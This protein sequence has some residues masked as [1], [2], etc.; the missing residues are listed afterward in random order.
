[1]PKITHLTYCFDTN[2]CILRTFPLA[3]KADLRTRQHTKKFRL[4]A[5]VVNMTTE[6]DNFRHKPKGKLSSSESQNQHSRGLRKYF[7]VLKSFVNSACIGHLF[8]NTANQE[9]GNTI[10]KH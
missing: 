6:V 4:Y 3:D 7:I 9:Q 10:V 5:Q 8:S 1:M 2:K